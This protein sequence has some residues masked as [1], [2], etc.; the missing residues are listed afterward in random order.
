[1]RNGE[2]AKIEEEKKRDGERKAEKGCH[3]N[4]APV[5]LGR[6]DGEFLQLHFDAHRAEQRRLLVGTFVILQ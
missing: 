5:L 2:G 6:Q 1:M 3:N 4:D